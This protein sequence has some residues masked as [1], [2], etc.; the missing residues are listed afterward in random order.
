MTT[1][2]VCRECGIGG[3]NMNALKNIVLVLDLISAVLLTIAIVLQSS[4]TGG[5]TGAIAGSSDSFMSRG[6]SKTLD[7]RLATATKW[8]GV[9]FVLL[10]LL[11]VILVSSVKSTKATTTT[12]NDTPVATTAASVVTTTAANT[13]A[14]TEANTEAAPATTAAE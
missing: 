5:L 11:A 9:A 3:L 7:A 13:E 4:K 14:V 6:G 12:S 1:A 2:A 10:S 8:L